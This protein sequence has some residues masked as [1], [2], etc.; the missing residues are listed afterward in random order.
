[1]AAPDPRSAALEGKVKATRTLS[2]PAIYIQGA[3]DGVNPRAAAASVPDNFTGPFE[4]VQ[5]P[6][7]GHFPQRE[8]PNAVTDHLLTLFTGSTR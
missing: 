7:V 5:L 1:M 8:A 2:L 6:G 3:V 4:F